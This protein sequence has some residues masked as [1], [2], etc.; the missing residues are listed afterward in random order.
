MPVLSDVSKE[1]LFRLLAAAIDGID[2]YESEVG[3]LHPYWQDAAIQRARA[4]I[5][6]IKSDPAQWRALCGPSL[7]I[8]P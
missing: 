6:D 4:I 2:G 8:D 1:E 3:D 7:R 5:D